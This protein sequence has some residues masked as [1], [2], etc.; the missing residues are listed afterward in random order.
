MAL[1]TLSLLL[2]PAG[3]QLTFS[4]ALVD[5]VDICRRVGGEAAP[6]EIIAHNVSPPFVDSKPLPAG[7]VVEYYALHITPSGQDENRS[8]VVRLVMP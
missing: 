6:W 2:V 8:N 1:A 4:T 3:R 7:V 5:I